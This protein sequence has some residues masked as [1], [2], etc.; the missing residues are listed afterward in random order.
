MSMKVSKWKHV[1]PTSTTISAPKHLEMPGLTG[2]LCPPKET[3]WL[4]FP[5][6]RDVQMEC[7]FSGEQV[8]L[9]L[10]D[11]KIIRTQG[12]EIPSRRNPGN[13]QD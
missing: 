10:R 5:M 9:T 3:P 2:R 6:T 12:T 4:V 1:K 11:G 8:T 7:A 13:S